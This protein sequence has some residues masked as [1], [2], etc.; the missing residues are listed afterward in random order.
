MVESPHPSSAELRACS[1]RVFDRFEL[2]LNNFVQ[3]VTHRAS[4][5]HL[6]SIIEFN[7]GA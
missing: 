6:E 1:D 4:K 5:G 3:L 2:V 7:F